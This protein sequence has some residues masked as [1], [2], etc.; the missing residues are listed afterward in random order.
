MSS[1]YVREAALR[2]GQGVGDEKERERH[3]ERRDREREREREEEER[4]EKR[5]AERVWE[6][7]PR[8]A[9]EERPPMPLQAQATVGC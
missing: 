6:G 1:H 9:E 8:A 4:R 7:A 5:E 3:R 2:P